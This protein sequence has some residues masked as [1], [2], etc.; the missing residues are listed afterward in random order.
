MMEFSWIDQ[1]LGS[2]ISELFEDLVDVEALV[3]GKLSILNDFQILK[4]PINQINH[5]QMLAGKTVPQSDIL[6]I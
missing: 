2:G 6:C 5:E 3:I 4:L 1:K